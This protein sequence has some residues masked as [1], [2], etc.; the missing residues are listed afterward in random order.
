MMTSVLT[1][2][3]PKTYTVT[4][5]HWMLCYEGRGTSLVCVAITH[6]QTQICIQQ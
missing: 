3:R 1:N 6:S 2:I 4:E 5:T